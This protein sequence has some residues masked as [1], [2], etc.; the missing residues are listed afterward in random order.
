MFVDGRR[1]IADGLALIEQLAAEKS[2]LSNSLSACREAHEQLGQE[3]NE[4]TGDLDA[5][6]NE[7]ATVTSQLEVCSVSDA[8]VSQTFLPLES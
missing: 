1:E 7:C 3:K 8:S 2:E 6:R 5:C 4:L